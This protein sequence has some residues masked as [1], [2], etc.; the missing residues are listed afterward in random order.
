MYDVRDNLF[1]TVW[2]FNMN[3][4]IVWEF[5]GHIFHIFV[6]LYGVGVIVDVSL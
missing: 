4:Y 6:P 1:G 2:H 5:G 3:I